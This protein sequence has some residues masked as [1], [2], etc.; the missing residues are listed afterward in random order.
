M[1]G[2]LG[3]IARNDGLDDAAA[4]PLEVRAPVSESISSRAIPLLLPFV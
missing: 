4:Y 1:N 3:W 2:R